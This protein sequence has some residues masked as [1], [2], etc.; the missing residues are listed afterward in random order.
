MIQLA[1]NG[2]RVAFG[3][4]L[5]SCRKYLL[6][7]ANESLDSGLRPKGGASDLVQDTFFEAQRD[8]GRF[9]GTTERE[10]LA[11]L[12]EILAHRLANH[13]RRYGAQKRDVDRELPLDA[14]GAVNQPAWQQ[15]LIGPVDAAIDRDEQARLAAAISR[16]PEHVREVI[17]MR[18]WQRLT[19]PEIAARL[20]KTSEAAR[21]QWG[22]AVR[23]LQDELKQ[24]P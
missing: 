17:E 24:H 16:L 3:R 13:A 19:F 20:G 4:L 11:W 1:R 5:E 2:S 9:R 15:A 23:R 18:T 8:F 7:V 21:K 6:F 10:L 22:R 14:E 12:K